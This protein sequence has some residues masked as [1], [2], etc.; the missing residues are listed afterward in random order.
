M[1]NRMPP[2]RGMKMLAKRLMLNPVCMRVTLV[3]VCVEMALFG[4]RYLLGGVLSYGM[5]DLAQYGA[6]NSGIY[7][8]SE[9][10]SILFRMDLT[11]M[12]LAIPLTYSQIARFLILSAIAFLI[13][14]PLRLGT[15]E[16][17]W[18]TLRGEQGKVTQIFQWFREKNRLG[19]AI[20]V[21]FILEVL[22][23]LVGL[24]ATIPAFYLFY[25]FYTT[26]PSMEA[27]TTTSSLLQLAGTIWALAA[28]LFAF[29]LHSVFLPVR[30]CLCAHPEYSL[31]MTFRRGFQSTKGFRG[32]FFRFRLSYILWYFLSQMSYGAIDLIAL[33]Y[34]SLGSMIFLQE[35]ARVRE[36][37]ETPPQIQGEDGAL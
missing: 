10:V 5:V 6:T 14:A 21:E 29:W 1:T 2:R 32:A 36:G 13:A 18:G 30:Y 9:G 22:V 7:F 24:V 20:V 15:M 33:P 37:A 25:L 11:Q 28:S 27:F 8:N 19:K 23:R 17:Y 12:V 35:A 3:L 34:T 16:R 4:L 31:S 26:T